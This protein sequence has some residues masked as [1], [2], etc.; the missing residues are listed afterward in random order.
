MKIYVIND[1]WYLEVIKKEENGIIHV[2]Y[3]PYKDGN[4]YFEIKD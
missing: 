2:Y 3:L 4:D 1:T